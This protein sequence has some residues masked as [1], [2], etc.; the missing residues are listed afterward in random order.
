M[1]TRTPTD[2]FGLNRILGSGRT[3]AAPT[4]GMIGVPEFLP[5]SIQEGCLSHWSSILIP[6][7]WGHVAEWLRSGLQ[8][9]LLRFNSGRGLHQINHLAMTSTAAAEGFADCSYPS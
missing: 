4:L 8:N 3:P 6:A 2:V 5:D 1:T 9:R 7:R